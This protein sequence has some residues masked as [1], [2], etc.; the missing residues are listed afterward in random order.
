VKSKKN[1][2]EKK[3]TRNENI[4]TNIQQS[5]KGEDNIKS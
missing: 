1:L 4:D 5:G 3:I 2:A